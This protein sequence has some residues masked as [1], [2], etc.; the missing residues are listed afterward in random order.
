[1]YSGPSP[2][3]FS[4]TIRHLPLLVTVHLPQMLTTTFAM[5]C[6]CGAVKWQGSLNAATDNVGDL[7]AD[8][9]M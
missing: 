9:S 6:K 7:L 8:C 2:A 5:Q 1:M 3:D 4:M